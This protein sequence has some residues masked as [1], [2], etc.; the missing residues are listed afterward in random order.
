M[1][2]TK[3]QIMEMLDIHASKLFDSLADHYLTGGIESPKHNHYFM[4]LVAMLLEDK[5]AAKE[6]PITGEVK[7][8]LT[9]DY[10]KKIDESLQVALSE[11]VI[12][13]PW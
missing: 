3:E 8:T 1:D 7:W 11:N 2:L 6:D 9:D 13:G 5:I 12:K 10:L 4:S